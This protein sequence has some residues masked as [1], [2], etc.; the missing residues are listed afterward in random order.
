MKERERRTYS[1][2]LAFGIILGLVIAYWMARTA[3]HT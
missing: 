2:G 1:R 3:L